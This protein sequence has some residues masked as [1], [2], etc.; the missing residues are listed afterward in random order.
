MSPF[1]EPITNCFT[2]KEINRHR[3]TITIQMWKFI[4]STYENLK[5]KYQR[6]SLFLQ[7]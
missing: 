2:H 1:T 6:S 7:M 4:F 3:Y 5:Y